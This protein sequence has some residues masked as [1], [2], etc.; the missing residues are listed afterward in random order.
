MMRQ[1]ELA[2]GGDLLS[3]GQGIRGI[4]AATLV[5]DGVP[6]N[7][8]DWWEGI[9]SEFLVLLP[10]V[11]A[12][13]LRLTGGLEDCGSLIRTAYR[14]F[15]VFYKGRPVADVTP[16]LGPKRGIGNPEKWEAPIEGILERARWLAD[17]AGLY[18]APWEK[19]GRRAKRRGRK[20]RRKHRR[21]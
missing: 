3:Y 12:T 9:R 1:A 15:F 18:Y 11:P 19:R 14:R 4:K 20:P 6:W 16:L 2:L 5:V 10:S 21:V 8:S 13:L 7:G 17:Y